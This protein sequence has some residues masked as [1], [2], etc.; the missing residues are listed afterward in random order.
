MTTL[1]RAACL[2]VAMLLATGGRAAEPDAGRGL[3][4]QQVERI[5]AD[6]AQTLERL[7]LHLSY[8]ASPDTDESELADAIEMQFAPPDNI[9]WNKQFEV[10]DDAD[11][12]NLTKDE[13]RLHVDEY[14]AKFHFRVKGKNAE[15]VRLKI[16]DMSSVYRGENGMFMHVVY[17]Q[18]YDAIS[19]HRDQFRK[20]VL[21]LAYLRIEQLGAGFHTYIAGLDFA[22]TDRIDSRGK[23]PVRVLDATEPSPARAEKI[24]SEAYYRGMLSAGV[25]ALQKDE[26]PEAY[27]AFREARQDKR[28]EPEARNRLSQLIIR[29]SDKGLD[30]KAGIGAGL[31]AAGD[32][33]AAAF[34][35]EAAIRCYLYAKEADPSVGAEVSRKV[36]VLSERLTAFNSLEELRQNGASAEALA[37]YRAAVEGDR[38]NP[39]L[40]LGLAEAHANCGGDSAALSTFQA[41]I[42]AAPAFAGTYRAFGVYFMQRRTFKAA[43]ESFV[44]HQGMAE[45]AAD[46][47]LLAQIAYTKGMMLIADNQLVFAL[48][49][50][51]A[52]LR[53]NPL[54]R[55]A[56]VGQAELFL[57]EQN[58]R[59]GKRAIEQALGIDSK[60]ADAYH[61]LGRILEA[62]SK[63]N[64][65]VTVKAYKAAVSLVTSN[66]E[67]FWDLGKMLM[68][69]PEDD[70]TPAIQ[71]FTSCISLS[72]DKGLGIQA[73][74][75]RGKCYM[76]QRKFAEAEEDLRKFEKLA[77]TKLPGFYKDFVDVLKRNGK[78]AEAERYLAVLTAR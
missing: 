21:K 55:E 62:E 5:R 65:S 33:K 14:L 76:L 78:M 54:M 18:T 2:C 12:G 42:R 44:K 49:S 24:R 43:H 38:K 10:D 50:L 25:A 48:D 39:V 1:K 63:S 8:L 52:A 9:F 31:L 53:Y 23:D 66:P 34:Q 17:S 11:P 67:Y 61:K 32:R 19:P 56:W 77:Y 7:G 13:H 30:Y 36:P 45:D 74:W 57:R 71:C 70:Y 22:T 16:I 51:K 72:G 47:D 26:F 73:Y 46:S 37:G 35:Y 15:S 75:K 64:R 69:N 6:A 68:D 59:A 27:Y 3:T 29:M 58:F 40:L 60:F 20:D 28:T 4:R 41:A